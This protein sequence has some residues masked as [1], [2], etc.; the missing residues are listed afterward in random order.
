MLFLD[1]LFNLCIIN[2]HHCATP[3]FFLHILKYK[4]IYHSILSITIFIYVS[5]NFFWPNGFLLTLTERKTLRFGRMTTD[6]IFGQSGFDWMTIDL[7]SLMFIDWKSSQLGYD[8]LIEMRF[9]L[10]LQNIPFSINQNLVNVQFNNSPYF[11]FN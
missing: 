9:Y 5:M 2:S 6:Q 7:M 8:Y 10:A 1:F 3:Q 11:L 4:F